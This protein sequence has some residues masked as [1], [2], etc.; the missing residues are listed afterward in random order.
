MRR[1]VCYAENISALIIDM[2]LRNV[3]VG[4]LRWM[5]EAGTLGEW[6]IPNISKT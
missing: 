3:D 4:P 1:N 2:I 5:G 6:E